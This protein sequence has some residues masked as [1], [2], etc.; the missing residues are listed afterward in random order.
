MGIFRLRRA[1]DFAPPKSVCFCRRTNLHIPS[2]T[3]EPLLAPTP[4]VTVCVL[5]C[6]CLCVYLPVHIPSFH[7]TDVV[8][9]SNAKQTPIFGFTQMGALQ[10]DTHLV[11]LICR[12]LFETLCKLL[13]ISIP[14]TNI[15]HILFFGLMLAAQI[16]ESVRW[17]FEPE[18]PISECFCLCVCV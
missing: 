6:V 4:W 1:G 5:L 17:Y 10:F 16:V 18:K 7:F 13:S 3:N 11:S 14:H 8:P 15:W 2:A 12:Q 9:N